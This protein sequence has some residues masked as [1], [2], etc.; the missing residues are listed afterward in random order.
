MDDSSNN[1]TKFEKPDQ[2]NKRV[3]TARFQLYEI[4]QIHINL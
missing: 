3:H 2:K 4:I 1:Y